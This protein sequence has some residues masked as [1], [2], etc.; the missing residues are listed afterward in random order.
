M[1][2]P[3][4]NY[5]PVFKE[6]LVL[7]KDK[8]LDFLGLTDIAPIT[9][10]LRT[11]GVEIEIKSTFSDLTFGTQDGLGLNFEEEVSLSMDDLLRFGG[12][13]LGLSRT[14]KREFITVIF[15][16][17]PSS[18]TEVKTRQMHFKPIIVQCSNIDA[19][20]MLDGLKKD[21]ADGKPINELK[22][23]YLPLF[24][25]IKFSPTE[26]YKESTK[27]IRDLQVDDERRR[28]IF[29]LSTVLAGK[30]VDRTAIAEILEEVKMMGNIIL[31]VAESVGEKRGIE[32]QQEESARKMLADNYDALD[33]I[34]Y[35]GISAERLKILRDEMRGEVVPA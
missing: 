30:V 1:E 26:L 31:E 15:L 12:Y 24:Y 6:S 2:V 20:E 19:D 22:L 10:P 8:A 21:I 35:T 23:V 27:L 28:K 16:K 3:H 25:S 18:I 4:Q 14:Y 11:E 29:A 34:T 9:E 32:R 33:I 17:N 5:D 7:F 13:N